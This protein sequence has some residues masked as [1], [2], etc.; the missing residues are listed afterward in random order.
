MDKMR[1]IRELVLAE[2]QMEESGVVDLSAGFDPQNDLERE[3]IEFMTDL[4]SGFV[5]SASA[6]NQLK[7]SSLG[8]IKIY[9]ISKTKADFMLFRNGFKMIFSITQPGQIAIYFNQMSSNFIPTPGSSSS[10]TQ[11]EADL[12]TAEWG[13]FGDLEWKFNDKAIKIDHLIRYYLSR[14]VR[15]S[16]K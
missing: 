4:K 12:L 8:S 5:E 10:S 16:A 13:A 2:Q 11:P 6:F 3:S 15:D 1:W 14:F 7:G 9:G